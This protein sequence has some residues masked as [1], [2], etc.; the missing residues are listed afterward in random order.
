MKKINRVTNHYYLNSTLLL[1]LLFFLPKVSYCQMLPTDIFSHRGSKMVKAIYA[2][3]FCDGFEEGKGHA[4]CS[5]RNLILFNEDG[6]IFLEVNEEGN[7]FDSTLYF[8]DLDKRLVS[9]I[10]YSKFGIDSSSFKYFENG[11]YN[12]RLIFIHTK[13]KKRNYVGLIS[14]DNKNNILEEYFVYQNDS[15]E[16][17]LRVFSYS[18]A[19]GKKTIYSKCDGKC[20]DDLTEE[21]ISFNGKKI[22]REFTFSKGKKELNHSFEYDPKGNRVKYVSHGIS[23]KGHIKKIVSRY[24]KR[25]DQIKEVL[26]RDDNSRALTLNM[27]YIYDEHKNWI[28]KTVLKDGNVYSITK[29]T[30][31]Y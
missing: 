26:Y 30:I 2:T 12:E 7:F 15:S 29:R 16:N 6:N 17:F 11:N 3:K 9:K 28:Q 4:D 27:K 22:I 24:N 1:T 19:L 23:V 8:Y 20:N 31:E 14:Y 13:Y 18:E 10:R 25:N 21:E 5:S